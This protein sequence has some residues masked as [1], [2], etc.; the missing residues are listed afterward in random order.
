MLSMSNS[1]K[2]R[3]NLLAF[4]EAIEKIETY[5]C[6]FNNGEDFYYDAKS[7]VSYL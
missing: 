4:I 6:E 3:F 7:P 1:S 2:I 5:T